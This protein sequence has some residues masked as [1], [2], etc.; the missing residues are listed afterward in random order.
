MTKNFQNLMKNIFLH[1]QVQKIPSRKTQEIHTKHIKIK[2]SK[3]QD[4]D[5]IENSKKIICH[6]QGMPNK[7]NI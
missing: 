7:S 3:N 1:I 4:E 6:T 5:N 2:L